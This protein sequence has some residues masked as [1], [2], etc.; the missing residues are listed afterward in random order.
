MVNYRAIF[1]EIDSRGQRPQEFAVRGVEEIAMIGKIWD[2]SVGKVG[3]LGEARAP[4]PLFSMNFSAHAG[5]VAK[6][7]N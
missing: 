2:P 7:L 1:S 4:R 5:C 6:K 3:S